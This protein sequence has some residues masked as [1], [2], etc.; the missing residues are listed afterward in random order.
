MLQY[1]DKARQK[2]WLRKQ[3]DRAAATA[4]WQEQQGSM[5]KTQ[6]KQEPTWQ[7]K[8]PS[9]K[10]RQMDARQDQADFA[11]EY[12]MLRKLKRGKLSEVFSFASTITESMS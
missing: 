9:A 5:A 12:S 7:K 10:R 1:K 4:A 11:A 8:L 6:K 3:A 2:Q